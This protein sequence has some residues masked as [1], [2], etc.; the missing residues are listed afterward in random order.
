VKSVRTL[1]GNNFYKQKTAGWMGLSLVKSSGGQ[2][3]I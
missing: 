3:H 2:K 1:G